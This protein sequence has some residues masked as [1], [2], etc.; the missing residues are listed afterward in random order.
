MK[1]H[2]PHA[3]QGRT[4]LDWAINLLDPGDYEELVQC[5]AE[6]ALLEDIWISIKGAHY[7]DEYEYD[8]RDIVSDVEDSRRKLINKAIDAE[9][10]REVARRMAEVG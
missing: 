1:A 10:E 4:L 6:R 9:L 5:D 8:V 3:Y 2:D 7:A